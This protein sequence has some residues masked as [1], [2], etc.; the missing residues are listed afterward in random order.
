LEFAARAVAEEPGQAALEHAADRR[1]DDP[2]RRHARGRSGRGFR[3]TAAGA[4]ARIP[5]AVPALLAGTSENGSVDAHAIQPFYAGLLARA[6]GLELN[7]KADGD[8][9]VI[10]TR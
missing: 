7:L 6:C 10:A 5:Q 1:A 8:A 4:N 2:T 3:I 9:I